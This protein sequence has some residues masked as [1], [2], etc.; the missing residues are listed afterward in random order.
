[1]VTGRFLSIRQLGLTRSSVMNM[2]RRSIAFSVVLLVAALRP[3][4]GQEASVRPV[5][6]VE[7][8]ERFLQHA[9]IVATRPTKR[10]SRERACCGPLIGR[11]G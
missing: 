8:T 5:L 9:D 10:G 6:A 1:M 2:A 11:C 3:R 7:E 4:L